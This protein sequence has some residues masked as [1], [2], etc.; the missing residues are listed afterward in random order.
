MKGWQM[1][2]TYGLQATGQE[3]GSEEG[4]EKETRWH[5]ASVG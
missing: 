1:A 4:K 2:R 5:W 3:P